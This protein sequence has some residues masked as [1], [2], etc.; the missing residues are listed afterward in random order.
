MRQDLEIMRKA[1]DLSF[2]RRTTRCST[3]CRSST[4]A[5]WCSRACACCSMIRWPRSAAALRSCACAST[6]ASRAAIS[7]SPR[8]SSS[9]SW[10]RSPS[11]ASIYPSK[12]E[13]ETELGRN[14]N[15]VEGIGAL[16][17]KYGLEGWQAPYAQLKDAARRLRRLGAADHSSQGTHGFSPAAA[18][19]TH[20]PSRSTASTCRRHRSPSMAHAA[21]AA[22]PG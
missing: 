16:F 10:S 15:Y 22:V 2:V 1:F 7:R 11:R 14:S 8:C 21:F 20:S 5:S 12:G 6:P 4:R 18:R 3:R 17:G 13:I 19:S 9:A